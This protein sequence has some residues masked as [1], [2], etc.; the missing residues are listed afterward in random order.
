MSTDQIEKLII[1]IFIF[2]LSLMTVY[3]AEDVEEIKKTLEHCG[4]EI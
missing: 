2:L 4:K 1:A 3:I